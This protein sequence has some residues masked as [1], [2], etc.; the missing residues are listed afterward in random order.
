MISLVALI[1]VQL[2]TDRQK[3][4]QTHIVTEYCASTASITSG[5]NVENKI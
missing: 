4:G 3:N 1:E 2:G 5:K